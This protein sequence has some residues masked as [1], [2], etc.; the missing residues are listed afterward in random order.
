MNEVTR[1]L[2]GPPQVHRD[3][4]HVNRAAASQI[5][6]AGVMHGFLIAVVFFL[7][8]TVL[9]VK[10]HK[11]EVA[12]PGI[13]TSAPQG[14]IEDPLEEEEIGGPARPGDGQK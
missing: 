5:H 8:A 1:S 10:V 13:P 7:V 12:P 9:F 11:D 14:P 4:D 3:P 6:A 2:T